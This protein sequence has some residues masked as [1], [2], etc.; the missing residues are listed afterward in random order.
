MIKYSLKLAFRKLMR[1]KTLSFIN[2]S[3][4]AI[5]MAC[6]VLIF[7]WLQNELSYDRFHDDYG[8]IYRVELDMYQENELE[9]T[10][11]ITQMPIGPALKEN[12]AEVS[13]FV[14]LRGPG[15][16]TVLVEDDFLNLSEIFFADS[17]LFSVFSY[18]LSEGNPAS[19][20]RYPNSIV[21]TAGAAKILFGDNTA[22]GKTIVYNGTVPLQV[23]GIIKN[24][25][26]NSHIKYQGFISF[27]TLYH[28]KPCQAWDCNY[29]F[30][31]Y[32]RLVPGM[33]PD[34][35]QAQ[36]PAF[37][38]EPHNKKLAT[39]NYREDIALRPVADIHLYSKSNEIER[40]GS[41]PMIYLFVAIGVFIILIACIN[42]INLTTAQLS[43]R[44]VEIGIKKV[45][46]ASRHQLVVQIFA[47][48]LIQ[49]IISLLL[50]II[51]V[52]LTLPAF[53]AV[54][55]NSLKLPYFDITFLGGILTL[56]T[57]SVLISGAYPAYFLT[58]LSP[59][60]IIK[61]EK[62]N[63]KYSFRT[64]LVVIQFTIAV[65]L[66]ASTAIIYSQ[67]GF[68]HDIELGFQK[69]NIITVPMANAQARDNYKNLMLSFGALPEVVQTGASTEIP[70]EG[71]TSNGYLPEG[72]NNPI[73]FSALDID[74]TYLETMGMQLVEGRNFN[75]DLE[76][77]K[78]AFLV[79]E[80]LVRNL[81]WEHAVG[82]IIERNGVKH[83][84]IGVVKDFHF[85]SARKEI[86]PLIITKTPWSGKQGY[87]Y[88][89]LQINSSNMH[90]TLGKLE[91][92]W[93]QQVPSLP[94]EY[95][96]LD[97]KIDNLYRTEEVLGKIFIYFTAL[98]VLISAMGVFGLVLFMVEQK[99]KEIGIRKVLGA[100]VANVVLLF[101]ALFTWRV[102]IGALLA[103][104]IT[105]LVMNNWLATFAYHTAIK[106]QHFVL[107]A[108]LALLIAM[109]TVFFH[110][111]KAA[112][113][114]PTEALKS[115]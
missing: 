40:G 98:A 66:I 74:E 7:L 56:L 64:V 30:Y 86:G 75:E 91:N 44:F 87:G 92:I 23:T 65:T 106:P 93:K 78:V 15:E 13:S 69:E 17:G 47:E 35:L 8:S 76:S 81:G 4:L 52:E 97:Q 77:D 115:E 28:S 113:K 5:G 95:S 112:L 105:L 22:I 18:Q 54:L 26:D 88:L 1:D 85:T 29:S 80:K 43:K 9:E 34:N 89:T 104:P 16:I 46:G 100:S 55:N 107:A 2:I 99:T 72:I 103:V 63:S 83:P 67:L 110:A 82:R 20:L 14:R 102:L 96:F 25:P 50:A 11:A 114:N 21:I 53:N 90:A 42:F 60:K 111:L 6:A 57:I 36:F 49:A 61:G 84:V 38:W 31:T 108:G 12:F 10:S 51:M 109:I 58:A 48:I 19:A 68:V 37:L 39:F 45:A 79:N 41:L 59:A 70:G 32:V 3:G 24:A 71:F 62:S 27:S 101:T 73:M 33:N 94:F